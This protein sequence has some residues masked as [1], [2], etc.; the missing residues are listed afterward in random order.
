MLD[1]LSA[2]EAAQL[3]HV[4][5]SSVKTR[6]YR[7]KAHLRGR[8]SGGTVM[9]G[10]HLDD[11][12]LRRYVERTDSLAKGPRPSRHLLACGQCRAKVNAA[13]DVIVRPRARRTGAPP[14]RR[15]GPPSGSGR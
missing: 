1:G 5:V 12:M 15:I 4:P 7:A 3:L 14:G 13:V 11:A 10:W 2:K 8:P 9:T 6:L